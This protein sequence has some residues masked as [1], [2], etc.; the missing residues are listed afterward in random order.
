MLTAVPGVSK[1]KALAL[2]EKYPN[3]RALM[4][5]L[6][7]DGDCKLGIKGIGKKLEQ[8]IREVFCE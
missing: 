2:S 8:S 5:K 3:P 1:A 4:K 7:E 6:N